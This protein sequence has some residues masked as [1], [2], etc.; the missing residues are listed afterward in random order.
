MLHG[1]SKQRP[2]GDLNHFTYSN[3]RQHIVKNVSYAAEW[4]NAMHRDSRHATV[5]DLLFRSPWS[6]F[7]TY[8]LQRGFLDGFCGFV[9]AFVTGFYT[10]MKYAMLRELWRK[11][12]TIR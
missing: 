9:I 3:I 7:R 1:H 4:A 8:V 5:F 12:G 6:V 11:S 10:F 2:A